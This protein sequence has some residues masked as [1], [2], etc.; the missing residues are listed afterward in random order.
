MKKIF[1]CFV[2][3]LIV[4]FSSCKKEEDVPNVSKNIVDEVDKSLDSFQNKKEESDTKGKDISGLDLSELDLVVNEARETGV[5]CFMAPEG[6]FEYELTEE[7]IRTVLPD[8]DISSID[9]ARVEYTS[10]DGVAKILS[11]E[12]KIDQNPNTAIL[13]I[14][15]KELVVSEIYESSKKLSNI[16]DMPV[17]V[18]V[19]PEF[20]GVKEYIADF[21]KDG[22]FYK[23]KMDDKTGDETSFARLLYAL[24]DMDG[25]DLTCLENPEIPILRNGDLTLEEAYKEENFGKYMIRVPDRYVFNGAMA[26][27]NQRENYQSA[28]WSSDYDDINEYVYYLDDE[29]R[30]CLIEDVDEVERYDLN[31]LFCTLS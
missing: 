24:I 11:V 20:R 21:E 27:I 4:L 6:Y 14:S 18:K 8:Y 29:T 25:S 3:I 17:L 2:F 9:Y 31:R 13:Y 19:L 10:K 12:F 16:L 7:E 1:I 28:S 26:V 22:L 15:P 23:L 5:Q 30:A